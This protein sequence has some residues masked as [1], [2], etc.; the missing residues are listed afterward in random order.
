M[1]VV[2]AGCD[3]TAPPP[4]AV[5]LLETEVAVMLAWVMV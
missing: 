1:I 3:G 2:V 5:A 4:E